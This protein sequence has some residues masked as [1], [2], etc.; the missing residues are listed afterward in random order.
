RAQAIT[1]LNTLR[2]ANVSETH[3]FNDIGVGG[4]IKWHP[5]LKVDTIEAG[6][7]RSR[8]DVDVAL[9][10][11]MYHAFDSIRGVLDMGF[12]KGDKYEFQ[13]VLEYR[14]VW[15][16]NQ[17]RKELGIRYRKHYSDPWEGD[18][19]PQDMLDDNGEPILM[20]SPCL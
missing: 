17:V 5:K 6:G 4:E 20:P 9:A 13:S 3:P 1:F 15:F 7:V 16:E 14:A 12:V 8:L 18:K 19:D 10:H 2:M 11:Q